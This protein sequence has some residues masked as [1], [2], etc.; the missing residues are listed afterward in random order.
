MDGNDQPV[1]R[2]TK[3]YRVHPDNYMLDGTVGVENLSGNEQRV[4]YGLNGPVGLPLEGG[5]RMDMRKVI[6]AF[7]TP[8]GQIQSTGLDIKALSKADTPKERELAPRN[9][10][11]TFLWAATV[12]K[13]FA[14]ILVPMTA[15]GK[16]GADWI[17]GK[18]GV[19]YNPDQDAKHNSGD[20]S[21]GFVVTSVA[22]TLAPAGQANSAQTNNFDLYLG[23]KDKS[24]FDKVELYRTLGFVQTIDFMACCCPAGII[25][26]LAF[27]ILGDHEL[28]VLHHPEL[29]HRH[30]H[31]GL[32]HA[33]GPA[34]DHQEEPDRD[35]QDEQARLRG[36]RRSSRS[37]AT[38]RPR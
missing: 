30:H 36:P 16:P 2:L 17:A 9:G 5:Y 6:A 28:D 26:P 8:Q 3:T 20:E 14:G 21:L 25:N 15:D 27:G 1:L 24:R 23:P 29:R 18:W 38:T 34:P 31:P 10:D 11:S 13:Y 4:Y 37:T 19:Y 32:H 7:R 33:A 12:S 22:I 35:E